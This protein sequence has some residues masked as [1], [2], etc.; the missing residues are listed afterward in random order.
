MSLF[1][2]RLKIL[3]NDAKKTQQELAESLNISKQTISNYESGFREPSIDIICEFSSYFNASVDYLLGRS[4]F[5]NYDQ[6]YDFRRKGMS[7][8]AL[9]PFSQ[10]LTDDGFMPKFLFELNHLMISIDKNYSEI[11]TKIITGNQRFRTFALTSLDQLF[12]MI[13]YTGKILEEKEYDQDMDEYLD[14]LIKLKDMPISPSDFGHFQANQTQ[15]KACTRFFNEFI[16]L[17][18]YATTDLEKEN[19]HKEV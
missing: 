10:L 1:K 17:F 13:V 9:N 19:L 6:E 11:M 15:I 2:I 14:F 5:K 3:R 7:D 18:I 8:H 16:T 4:E 12:N